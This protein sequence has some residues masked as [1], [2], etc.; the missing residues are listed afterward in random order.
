MTLAAA[1]RGKEPGAPGCRTESRLQY[2]SWFFKLYLQSYYASPP[3]DDQR[4]ISY[5]D[6]AG[7]YGGL[8][9]RGNYVSDDWHLTEKKICICVILFA[10]P[11]TGRTKLLVKPKSVCTSSRGPRTICE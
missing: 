7:H 3:L 8:S 5:L 10:K 4:I 9:I 2:G 6:K 1:P 11:K